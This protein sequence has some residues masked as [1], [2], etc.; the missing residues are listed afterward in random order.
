MPSSPDKQQGERSPAGGFMSEGACTPRWGWCSM[1]WLVHR[2][3]EKHLARIAREHA[4]G[5]LLDIGCGEK[6]Y[7]TLFAPFVKEH[8]GLDHAETQHGHAAIDLYGYAEAI[9]AEALS[10]D[11][12]LCTAVLEHVKEPAQA[13]AE[14]HRVLRSG[15]VVI[16][17][18]PFFWHIHE[19]P[20][21][22]YRYTAYGLRYLME[23]AG[24]TISELTPLSGFIVTFA[25]ELV[26]FLH[27]SLPR[28]L[29]PLAMPLGTLIQGA[30]CIIAPLD[31]S[32]HFT[33]MYLV[34]ARKP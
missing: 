6:P 12:V 5:R 30:A 29:V 18:A 13:V 27:D 34:V 31:R 11:T 4:R 17:T 22:F 2:I 16:L 14:M 28:W 10:F 8:I 23:K 1:N 33:W 32:T 24:F 9:P 20:R 26:Y 3:L 21:D 25:Q 19:A 15:G 7:R